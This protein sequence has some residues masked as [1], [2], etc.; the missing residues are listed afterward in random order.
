MA[1]SSTWWQ[2]KALVPEFALRQATLADLVNL[3]ALETACFEP[4]RRASCQSLRRSLT[5]PRQVVWVLAQGEA[6]AGSMILWHHPRTTRIYGL[7]IDA[8]HRGGGLGERLMKHAVREARRMGARRIVLEADA[9]RPWLVAW[10]E[11]LGYGKVLLKP[12]FYATGR[13]VW[14]LS[15]AAPFGE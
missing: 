14:R 10:Y 8:A 12:N 6:I 3:V 5:S 4:E 7:A 15:R 11:R 9:D 2:R 13:G 1:T